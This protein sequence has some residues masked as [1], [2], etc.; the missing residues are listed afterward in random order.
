MIRVLHFV[1]AINNCDFV[2]TVLTR[3]D[4]SRFDVL[5]VTGTP[6]KRDNFSLPINEYDNHVLNFSFTRRNYAKMLWA[7]SREIRDYRPHILHAHHYD[8]NLIASI[9]RMC[10]KIPCYV[11]GHHY[12]D[13]IYFLANG[14]RR[15]ALLTA[16]SLCNRMATKIVVPSE[17]VSRILV[18]KQK[19]PANKVKV[20]PYGIDV[21]SYR[22]SSPDAPNEIRSRYGLEN[23]YVAL[24]CCRINREKGL[25]YLLQAVSHFRDLEADAFRL[26]IVGS[27]PHEEELRRMCHD[28]R[29]DEIVEFVGWQSQPLDWM[30]AADLVLI[31]SLCE[32]FCQVLVEAL[33]L[34]KPVIMTPVG[35]GPEVIGRNER[36][37]LVPKGDVDALAKAI[38][39]LLRDENLGR[40]LGGLGRD[41]VRTYLRA[42][43][44]ARQYELLYEAALREASSQRHDSVKSRSAT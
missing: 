9:L 41:Y 25:Q 26:V 29:I 19:V 40:R 43:H 13:H 1:S 18:Q 21:D 24:T 31:P 23:K 4:R 44:M 2:D 30:A 15:Q 39:E 6:L 8:E 36:G 38:E 37:R 33:A 5:A 32:S 7:L 20:V 42:E 35:A 14:L 10:G 34:G 11:N 22:P 27:G 16:E 3:L 17:E 28:L 12:S